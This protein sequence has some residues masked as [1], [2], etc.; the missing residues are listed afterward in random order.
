VLIKEVSKALLIL[1]LV[2]NASKSATVGSVRLAA[3]V[4]E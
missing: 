4:P 1:A 3:P 2:T